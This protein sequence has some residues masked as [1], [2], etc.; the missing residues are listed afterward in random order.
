MTPSPDL[1]E[2]RDVEAFV[3]AIESR[4]EARVGQLVS[5]PHVRARVNDP[6]FEFG[7]RAA[8]L[9]AK[10]PRILEALIAAG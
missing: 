7:Q 10:N 1:D 3:K 5:R 4:D 8:H 2:Q 9:V 6:M